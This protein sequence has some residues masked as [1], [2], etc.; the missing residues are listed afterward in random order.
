MTGSSD[1]QLL[2]LSCRV[3]HKTQFMLKEVLVQ[4]KLRGEEMA[5]QTHGQHSMLPCGPLGH[6]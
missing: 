3:R 6:G 1:Q 4:V 5:R 2:L